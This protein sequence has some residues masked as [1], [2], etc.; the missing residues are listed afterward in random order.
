MESEKRSSTSAAGAEGLILRLMKLNVAQFRG[1][2]QD[3]LSFINID[4]SL[5]SPGAYLTADQKYHICCPASGRSREVWYSIQTSTMIPTVSC[6][7]YYN[8]AIEKLNDDV[9]EPNGDESR[10]VS[11][12]QRAEVSSQRIETFPSLRQQPA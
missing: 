3:W 7:I 9:R 1:R 10:R 5:V 2:D 12:D 8:A 4:H 6:G 11:S